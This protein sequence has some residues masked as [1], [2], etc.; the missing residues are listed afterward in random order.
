MNF[1]PD[2]QQN[3]GRRV[4]QTIFPAVGRA[5]RFTVLVLFLGSFVI[6]AQVASG[7]DESATDNVIAAVRT[8]TE[9]GSR[10][11]T[12]ETSSETSSEATTDSEQ[13]SV[14]KSE[15]E[16]LRDRLICYAFLGGLMLVFLALLF[17]YLRLDHAT[18]RFH[19]A[20]LQLAAL[21]LSGIV[22]IVG[23]LLWTQVLFK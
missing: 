16:T 6:S 19:S 11:A 2:D 18:R 23:Y 8:D 20:R 4:C 21:V 10:S 7:Q 9:L 14:T 5:I 17:G 12:E 3:I 1:E 22:L 15:S 13:A